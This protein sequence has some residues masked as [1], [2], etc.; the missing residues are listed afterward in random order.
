[1]VAG[2][3]EMIHKTALQVQQI[4]VAAAVEFGIM[5]QLVRVVLALLLYLSQHQ[6][7]QVQQLEA[8]Q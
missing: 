6:P 2:N 4:L 7:I 3:L 1:V 8:Q 5:Q